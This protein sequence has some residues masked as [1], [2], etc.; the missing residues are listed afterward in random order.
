MGLDGAVR[1]RLVDRLGDQDQVEPA[2]PQPLQASPVCSTSDS[3]T[4]TSGWAARKA[5]TAAGSRVVAALAKVD[6]RT[7]PARSP[8]MARSSAS[9]ASSS[10]RMASARRTSARPASVSRTRR[11]CRST[12]RAPASRS[13]TAICWETAD[14]L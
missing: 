2:G 11:P 9:A 8:A 13:S 12:S 6:T 3:S 1:G 14:W 4:R 7:R 5:V 10:A